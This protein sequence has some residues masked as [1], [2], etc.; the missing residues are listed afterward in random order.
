MV[1]EY[2]EFVSENGFLSTRRGEQSRYWMH[3][4]IREGIYEQVFSDPAMQEE[5]K[6]MEKSIVEGEITSFMANA[7][8]PRCTGM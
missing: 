8:L 3:E 1:R 5:L 6:T 4:T 2:H 7:I